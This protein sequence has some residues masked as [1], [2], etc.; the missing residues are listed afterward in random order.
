M[1]WIVLVAGCALWWLAHAFRRIM[2]DQR[3]RL[4]D[5][6]KGL[7]A[8]AIAAGIVLMV[9]GYR[10][11]PYVSIWSPPSFLTHLNNLMVL[12]ALYLMSPASK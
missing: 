12:G 1:G 10:L 4:G 5:P 3:A 11:T 8:I 9:I 2:P 6:G 7:V